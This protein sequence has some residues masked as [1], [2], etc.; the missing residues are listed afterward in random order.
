[1]QVHFGAPSPAI[2]TARLEEWAGEANFSGTAAMRCRV[3]RRKCLVSL[4]KYENYETNPICQP[5]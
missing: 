3:A 1:M 5:Y 4:V 2:L